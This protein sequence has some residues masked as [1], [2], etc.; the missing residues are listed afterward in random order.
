MYIL[1]IY[2]RLDILGFMTTSDSKLIKCLLRCQVSL[3]SLAKDMR[4][5]QGSED[6]QTSKASACLTEAE[7]DL[8]NYRGL[9]APSGTSSVYRLRNFVY[10]SLTKRTTDK[11]VY[12]NK[13]SPF[14]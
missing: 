9:E 3:N 4:G 10:T 2:S 11:K 8:V 6:R 7:E 5:K 14:H 1:G 12:L 13:R